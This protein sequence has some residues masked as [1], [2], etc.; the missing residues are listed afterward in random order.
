MPTQTTPVVVSR[1]GQGATPYAATDVTGNDVVGND[2]TLL[3]EIDNRSG[4]TALTVN[5]DAPFP[6]D[7][8][9]EHDHSFV[10]AT[11]TSR[12]WGPFPRTQFGETVYVRYSNAHNGFNFIRAFK[13]AA[14]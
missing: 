11:G 5:I 10:V 1:D 14:A 6:C 8:G 3:L 2:G 13:P 9:V 12:L 7:H 4:T